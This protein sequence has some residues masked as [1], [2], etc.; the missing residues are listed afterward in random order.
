MPNLLT[1][2]R[3]QN[4]DVWRPHFDLHEQT[5]K[6]HGITNPRVYRNANDHN[7]LV[8]LF[9]VDDIERAK[10]FGQSQDLRSTMEKAGVI[11]PATVRVVP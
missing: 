8:L 10:E 6:A 11:M 1:Q 7:D 9:D 5:R 4:Y 3:V 2:H